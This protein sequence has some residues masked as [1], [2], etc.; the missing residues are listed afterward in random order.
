MEHKVRLL[1]IQ[2][3]TQIKHYEIE[4]FRRGVIN[5]VGYEGN[6]LFH[7]HLGKA[8][9]LY[10]YPFIQ[11]KQIHQQPS[12]V[13]LEQGVEAIHSLLAFSCWDLNIGQRKVNLTIARLDMKEEVLS[14]DNQQHF[15]KVLNWLALNK[16]RQKEYQE[17]TS[18]QEKIVLLE[19]ILIGNILSMS[20]SLGWFV[21][22]QI[23]VNI[24]EIEHIAEVNIKG[25]KQL[26]FT[27]K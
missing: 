22:S 14:I 19:S 13:C 24:H 12:I 11:Y 2:F 23:A 25:Q 16:T 4:L 18:D 9:F 1:R 5:K 27:L 10:Q 20:K 8:D 7:N 3:N 15:Y 26:A 6:T 17:L 21:D